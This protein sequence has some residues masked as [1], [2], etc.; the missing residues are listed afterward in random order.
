[1]NTM[2]IDEKEE[3]YYPSAKPP[4]TI[5]V[6][7]GQDD[8]DGGGPSEE[9]EDDK[10][11]MVA[12]LMS[13]H[14]QDISRSLLERSNL[15]ESIIRLSQHAPGCVIGSLLNDISRDRVDRRRRREDKKLR[16]SSTSDFREI[17]AEEKVCV[18]DQLSLPESRMSSSQRLGEKGTEPLPIFHRRESALLFVDISGFTKLSNMLDVESFSI[19][20]KLS[21]KFL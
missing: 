10:A 16:S 9:F 11:N 14:G 12:K 4:T 13:N 3:E 5:T 6:G 20:G 8:V 1:M 17:N 2:I 15:I 18:D 19:F 7:E 21:I